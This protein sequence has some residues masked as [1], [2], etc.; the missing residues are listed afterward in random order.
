MKI[1]NCYLCNTTIHEMLCYDTSEG[2][3]CLSCGKL[4][5]DNCCELS[6]ISEEDPYERFILC[7]TC[8]KIYSKFEDKI[9][10]EVMKGKLN[11]SDVLG[12]KHERAN[13][14]KENLI[15]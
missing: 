7:L 14:E 15:K 8:D 10:D 5:C 1:E 2:F 3:Q 13:K 9:Y 12:A 6:L 4:I 11:T